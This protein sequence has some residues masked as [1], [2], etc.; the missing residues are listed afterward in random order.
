MGGT[1]AINNQPE[2]GLIYIIEILLYKSIFVLLL[3]KYLFIGSLN[4]YKI[5]EAVNHKSN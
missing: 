3:K 1:A 2:L 4:F 5:A